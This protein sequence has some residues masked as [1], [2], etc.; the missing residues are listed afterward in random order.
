[1]VKAR[2]FYSKL[3]GWTYIV[4]AAEMG[5]YSTAQL[6]GHVVAGMGQP[7][8]GTNMPAAWSV[9]LATDDIKADVAKIHQLGGQTLFEPMEIP[10]QGMMAMLADPTGAVFG[11]WQAGNHIGATLT[12]VPGTMVWCEVNS[13]NAVKARDFYCAMYGLKGVP[14]EGAP[15]EYYMLQRGEANLA[16]VLQMDQNWPDSIPAHWIA[17]FAVAN[18]D[19]TAKLA[20]QSGG[21]VQ[22]EP[23]DGPQGRI[24]WIVDPLGAVFAVFARPAA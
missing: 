23:F 7:P 19:E 4:A 17:Y 24:A 20:V 15:I 3:F 10:A 11:L 5:Y 1:M 22:V 9:M 6:N 8:E 18:A 14:M 21:K 12:E 16:G 13:R 2:E